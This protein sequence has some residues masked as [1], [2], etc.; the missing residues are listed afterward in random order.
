MMCRL[1]AGRGYW[2]LV[3]SLL[4]AIV[5][6]G[7]FVAILVALP[8][9]EA[10]LF[11]NNVILAAP[12]PSPTATPEALAPMRVRI[13]ADADCT[14]CHGSGGAINVASVPLMAHPVQGWT[15]CTACHADDR[16]VKT[17]PG[18][19]GIHKDLCLA[20]HRPP[21]PG[22][23]ALPRPHHVV[24][25]TACTTCHGT[26]APLPTDM[27]GRQ[28][29]WLCHPGKDNEVLFDEPAEGPLPSGG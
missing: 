6:L 21:E 8:E 20:C 18:H 5:G 25:G 7:L 17:A 14:G 16:L 9:L 29:C 24:P 4:T 27:D 23:S 2:L 28:N 12:S 1:T 11:P 19:S 22:S 10:R 26:K 15:N 3:G 13:P